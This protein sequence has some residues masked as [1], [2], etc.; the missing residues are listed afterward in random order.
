[1][2]DKSDIAPLQASLPTLAANNHGVF[3]S[4][5]SKALQDPSTSERGGLSPVRARARA[6]QRPHPLPAHA[7]GMPGARAPVLDRLLLHS[8]RACDCT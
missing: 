1:M 2:F 8:R 4:E 7:C 3:P 5:A 6:P